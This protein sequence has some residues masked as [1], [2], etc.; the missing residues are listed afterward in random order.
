MICRA[1]ALAIAL[2]G[3]AH[4]PVWHEGSKEMCRGE[5][6]YRVGELGTAWQAV[7]KEGE[8]IGFYNAQVGGVIESNRTCR[9]DADPTPLQSLTNQMLIGYTERRKLDEKTVPLAG[10]EALRTRVSAKLDGVPV[11]LDL[12]VLKRNGCIFDFSYAAPPDSYPKGRPDFDAFVAGFADE[13][14]P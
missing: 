2:A 5:A 10:R 3:C 9:D 8:S 4:R 6:C 12:I 1:A 7:H 14:K 13:R 11:V